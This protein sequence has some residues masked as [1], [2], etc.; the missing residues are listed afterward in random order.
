[1]DQLCSAY[2]FLTCTV[3]LLSVPTA[4]YVS[5]TAW[6]YSIFLVVNIAFL[7]AFLMLRIEL[8]VIGEKKGAANYN[9]KIFCYDYNYGNSSSYFLPLSTGY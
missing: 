3:Y 7:V 8:V 1:M 4:G 5:I 9:G 2:V 6:K